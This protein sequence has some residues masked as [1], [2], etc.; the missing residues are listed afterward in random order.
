MIEINLI[1]NVTEW[2]S[3]VLKQEYALFTQSFKYGEFYRRMGEDGWIYGIYENGLL[4]GGSLV[5]SVHAKRGNFLFLPYGPIIG[6]ESRLG[7][8]LPIF[9]EKLRKSASSDGYDFIRVSP[10][11]D[12]TEEIKGVFRNAGFRDA[13][14]HIMAER[15]W[16]LDLSASADEILRNMEKNHRNLIKRCE[17]SG[18]V[19]SKSGDAAAAGQFNKIHDYTAERH[20]FHRFSKEYV[21]N[22]FNSFAPSGEALA[23][24]AFLSDGTLDSSAI[25]IYYGNMGAYRHGASLLTDRR[26]PSSYL[27]QW[28]AILEAKR[29][30]MKYYNFW[31]IAPDGARSTHPFYGISHFKKGFGGRPKELISCQDLPVTKRYWI[32]WLVEMTR[33]F[34]RGFK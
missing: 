2:E 21:L 16:I 18:A 3:F 34:R 29:L 15:T 31:G 22:E 32:N 23:F 1:E 12:N 24:S 8:L 13:P 27:I 6:D 9:F 28:E 30:G 25:I 14:I 11:L 19:V 17:K 5:V 20:N 33:S 26:I 10:F 7:E 4:L